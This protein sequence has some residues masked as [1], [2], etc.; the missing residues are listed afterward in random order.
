MFFSNT[1]SIRVKNLAL[2]PLFNQYL[3]CND[4]GQSHM[5]GSRVIDF[6]NNYMV[7]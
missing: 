3:F 6:P 7:K 5:P 2:N 1:N 4:M